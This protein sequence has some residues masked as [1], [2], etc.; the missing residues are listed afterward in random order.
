MPILLPAG[1][2]AGSIL[3][4]EGIL[5]GEPD[6][7][8]HDATLR[9]VL[10]NLMPLKP[11]AETQ[12]ARLL[13]LSPHR[14]ELILT[15]P[16]G[17]LARHTDPGHVDTFYTPWN[18]IERGTWDGLIVTGAPVETLPYAAVD[19][20]PWFQELCQWSTRQVG[21]SLFV[22]WSAQAALQQRYAIPKRL[23]G[24]KAFGIFRHGLHDRCHPLIRGLPGSF[25]VPVSRH[26][27]VA[28]ADVAAC[29]D[30]QVLA[31][32]PQ[33]GLCLIADRIWRSAYM[34]NHLEYD[35]L[36]LHQEYLRDL[37]AGRPIEP[38]SGYGRCPPLPSAIAFWRP[39][40][41]RLFGNWLDLIASGRVLRAKRPKAA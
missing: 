34:F 13:A 14:V 38:P 29:R 35:A 2:P 21:H 26:T 32:S 22:C 9:I 7:I 39:A 15:A 27:E 31:S 20:W 40:G 11:V 41:I 19:Y 5:C 36:S 28:K 3:R 16:P 4:S 23:L 33:S 25:P 37:A 17:H 24:A 12:F 8:R 18:T 6:P 1:L 30:L 10:V